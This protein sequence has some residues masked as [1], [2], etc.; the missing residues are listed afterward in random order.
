[1]EETWKTW[2]TANFQ[3]YRWPDSKRARVQAREIGISRKGDTYPP[4]GGF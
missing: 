1:M 3:V 2:K 4:V